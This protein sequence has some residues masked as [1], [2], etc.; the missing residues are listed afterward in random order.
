MKFDL[1]RHELVY[2]RV[3]RNLETIVRNECAEK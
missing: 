2:V 1:R 3:R